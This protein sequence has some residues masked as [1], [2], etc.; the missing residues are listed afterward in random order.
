MPWGK[1]ASKAV[2]AYRS[3]STTTSSIDDLIGGG[4]KVIGSPQFTRGAGG[5]DHAAASLKA[6]IADVNRLGG[7]QDVTGFTLTSD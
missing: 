6:A 2:M 5:I 1:A 3:V 7:P 4:V